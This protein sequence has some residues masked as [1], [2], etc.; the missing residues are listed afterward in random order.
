[1]RVETFAFFCGI[2]YVA[3]GLLGLVPVALQPL[4]ADAPALHVNT[5]YGYVLAVLPTNAVLS[6]LHL[7][8]GLWGIAAG[9][10]WAN[11]RR[12]AQGMAIIAGVLALAGFVPGTSTFGGLMPLYGTQ[13]WLHLATAAWAAYEGCNPRASLERRA[14]EARPD[15]RE[16]SVPVEHDRRTGHGDRRLP[17]SEV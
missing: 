2:A 3:A 5:M 10:S 9:R 6:V 1:M 11:P 15:R 7:A 8:L 14:G 16:H 13:A 12:Y 17:G 4:P